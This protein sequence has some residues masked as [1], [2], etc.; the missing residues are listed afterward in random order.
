M[1]DELR[2]RFQDKIQGRPPA[3]RR[4]P[5]APAGEIAPADSLLIAGLEHGAL[6]AALPVHPDFRHGRTRVRMTIDLGSGLREAGCSLD[7]GKRRWLLA[8]CPHL[9]EHECGAGDGLDSLLGDRRRRDP[10]DGIARETAARGQPGGMEVIHL[11]GHVALE[12]LAAASGARHCNAAACAY[13]ERPDRFDLYLECTDPLLGR[14]VAVLAA[15]SVRDIVAGR[16]RLQVH[17]CC[18]DLL[19]ALQLTD[20][21]ALVPEDVADSLGWTIEAAR[22]GLEAL[23]RLGFLE[24]VRAPFTFSSPGGVLYR[25]PRGGGPWSIAPPGRALSPADRSPAPRARPDEPSPSDRGR[26]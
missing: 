16:D 22:E 9:L 11:I 5:P 26:S 8:L 14:A 2:R 13:R 3:A 4:P 7:H 12:L 10:A 15:A 18:R 24:A 20:R 1:S 23:V 25:R 6:S 17:R 19:A 21:S